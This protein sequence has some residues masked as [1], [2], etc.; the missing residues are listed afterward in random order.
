MTDRIEVKGT[1]KRGYGCEDVGKQCAKAIKKSGPTKNWQCYTDEKSSTVLF[2]LGDELSETMIMRFDGS[3]LDCSFTVALPPPE[4]RHSK[5]GPYFLLMKMLYSLKKYFR[6]YEVSDE[7]GLWEDFLEAMKYEAAFCE[8][9]EVE[10]QRVKNAY[11]GGCRDCL[12]MLELFMAEDMG[13]KK[14]DT[15]RQHLIPLGDAVMGELYR[16]SR[17]YTGYELETWLF[18]TCEYKDQ[19]RVSEISC[20][21]AEELD[22]FSL[23]LSAFVFGVEELWPEFYSS[24]NMGEDDLRAFGVKHAIIRRMFRRKVRALYKEAEPFEKCV[25]AYRF[26]LS[27]LDYNGFTFVGP[28]TE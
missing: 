12:E 19:G 23:A 4:G 21:T 25:L 24:W 2:D 1:L 7:Q 17:D 22:G 14:G 6:E 9:T 18:K 27:A 11:E 16:D 26:F 28:E 3:R 13:L 5:K 10:M 8:L 15:V 20:G